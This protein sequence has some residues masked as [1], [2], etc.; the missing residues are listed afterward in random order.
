[1][2]KKYVYSPDAP[3]IQK[4]LYKISEWLSLFLAMGLAGMTAL[5]VA[6]VTGRYFFN[7]PIFGTHEIIGMLL[8]VTGTLGLA[9]C[10]R[11]GHHIVISL[12]VDKMPHGVKNA[13]RSF[14]LLI[15]FII[16][17][18][19]TY[20][21]FSLGYRYATKGTAGASQELGISL[22]PVTFVF[23]LGTGLYTLVLL[24]H[25]LEPLFGIKRR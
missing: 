8:V 23:T 22:A 6:D 17:A 15:S 20:K 21:M 14:A 12:I 18:L 25:L 24:L 9:I 4:G 3:A 10:E 2:S 13:L 1:M 19:I 11:D 5:T 16:Y 7:S